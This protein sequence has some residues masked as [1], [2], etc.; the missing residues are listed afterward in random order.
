MFEI[1]NIV[2]VLIGTMIG[3]GFASGK[4]IFIFFGKYGNLGII[5][6]I[7]SSIFFYIIINSTLKYTFNKK[8]YTYNSFIQNLFGKNFSSYV[9]SFINIFLLISFFIMVAGFSAFLN[10]EFNIPILVGSIIFSALLFIALINNSDGILNLNKILIPFLICIFICLFFYTINSSNYNI[11]YSYNS[12]FL[13]DALLYTSYNS[14]TII[15]II[16]SFSKNIKSTKS[17]NNI[18][19]I[20]T[21]IFL[22]LGIIVYSLLKKIPDNITSIE[23]PIMCLTNSSVLLRY[24]YGF[25]IMIAIFT[26]ALSSG[27]SLLEN[28]RNSPFRAFLLCIAAIPF[29]YIG[30]TKLIEAFYPIFGY[31][32]II[33]ILL[34]LLKKKHKTDINYNKIM[35]WR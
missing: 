10:Q 35:K 5:G 26:S 24:L 1:F 12:S 13:L 25:S 19:V 17:I 29:S 22:I 16:I 6:I 34:L 14:I 23:I 8:I 9:L 3:A 15:P 2:F 31:L 32:G 20:S 7:I 28:T 4:E 33:Q 27:Y 21:I 30:F 11:L 18:S